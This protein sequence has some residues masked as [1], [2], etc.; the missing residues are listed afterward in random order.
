MKEIICAQCGNT[1][2]KGTAV[3]PF[4]GNDLEQ[5]TAMDPELLA[6]L[7]AFEQKNEA[8]AQRARAKHVVPV[9][10]RPAGCG[11]EGQPVKAGSGTRSQRQ[12]AAARQCPTCGRTLPKGLKDCP[13]CRR[14]ESEQ[15]KVETPPQKK[16]SLPK[17]LGLAALAVLLV[18]GG[19]FLA[20]RDR[21]QTPR[22]TEVMEASDSAAPTE[23]VTAPTQTAAPTETTEAGLSPEEAMV[24]AQQAYNCEAELKEQTDEAFTF[25]C[26][27]AGVELGTV[28]VSRDG[29]IQVLTGMEQ[30]PGGALDTAE[31]EAR[32]RNHSSAAVYGWCLIDTTTGESFGSENR[33]TALS[34]SALVDLPILYAV[35]RQLEQGKLTMDTPVTVT[36]TS[37]GRGS[38]AGYYGQSFTLAQ[39]LDYVL[40]RSSNDAANAL[41]DHLGIETINQICHDAGFAS[42]RLTNHIG[43][44]VENTDSDNYISARDAAAIVDELYRATGTINGAYLLE[45]MKISGSDRNANRGL[46]RRIGEAM[47]GNHNGSTAYKYNEVILGRANDRIYVLCFMANGADATWLQ[48]AAAEIGEYCQTVMEQ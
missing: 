39:M 15:P 7:T 30:S 19:I 42:V 2:E 41:M 47:A 8:E 5:N 20:T 4:C 45:H 24:L 27:R 25:A 32:V 43:S 14:E 23:T 40:G 3:C 36:S 17:A 6:A 12:T 35:S 1:L 21:G 34:A 48:S 28:S 33:D 38:L 29:A 18:G 10:P 11:P 16:R 26:R 46:G 44:T 13:F 22:T 31:I 9:T 37:N